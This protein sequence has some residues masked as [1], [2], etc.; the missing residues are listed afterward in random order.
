MVIITVI[1]M[2][3]LLFLLLELVAWE[4]P[5]LLNLYIMMKGDSTFSVEKM[6][7][8]YREL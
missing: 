8:C 6:G 2:V 1:I 7:L 5:R 4:R 3:F